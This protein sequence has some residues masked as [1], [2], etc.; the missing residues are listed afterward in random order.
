[1]LPLIYAAPLPT[2]NGIVTI[3][4][5]TTLFQNILGST[6]AFIVIIFFI[7]IVVS[8]FKIIFSQGEPQQLAVAKKTLTMAI[9][10]MVVA[11]GAYLAIVFIEEITGANLSNFNVFIP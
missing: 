7:T 9:L 6:L 11:A 3:S 1:M 8:G 2:E 4:S 10:G 5:L